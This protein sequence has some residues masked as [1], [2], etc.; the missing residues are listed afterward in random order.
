MHLLVCYMNL[1]TPLMHRYVANYVWHIFFI[2]TI[3]QHW[4]ILG[5]DV[6]SIF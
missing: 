1:D 3:S 5:R 4:R 6:V 2:E